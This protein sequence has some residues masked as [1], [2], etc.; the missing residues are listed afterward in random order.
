MCLTP[1]QEPTY[2]H[3]EKPIDFMCNIIDFICGRIRKW[4][5]ED[6]ESMFWVGLP[7]NPEPYYTHRELLHDYDNNKLPHEVAR[8]LILIYYILAKD[9]SQN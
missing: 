6:K 4:S 5:D 2:S 7:D 8:E 1:R 3:G 9:T